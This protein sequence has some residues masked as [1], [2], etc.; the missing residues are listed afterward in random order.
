MADESFLVVGETYN[1]TGFDPVFITYVNLTSIPGYCNATVNQRQCEYCTSGEAGAIDNYRKN[2]TMEVEVDTCQPGSPFNSSLPCESVGGSTGDIDVYAT[3]TQL[4]NGLDI[5][6][7]PPVKIYTVLTEQ[8]IV[9]ICMGIFFAWLLCRDWSRRN[10]FSD[11]Y[12]SFHG[13]NSGAGV[14]R[15]KKSH[16]FRKK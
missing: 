14:G 5:Y 16:G 2:C 12:H 8:S 1:S 13:G 6:E 3:G 7:I 4:L 11:L 10:M 15:G 9:Y